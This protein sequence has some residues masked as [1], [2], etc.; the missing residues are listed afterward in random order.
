MSAEIVEDKSAQETPAPNKKKKLII[1]GAATVAALTLGGGGAAFF[2]GGKSATKTEAHGEET[3]AADEGHGE[4]DAKE[5]EGGHG[6]GEGK[7]KFVDVPT[8]SVNLRSPDGAPRFLKLH[9]MLVPGPKTTDAALKDKLPVVLDAYQPFLRE[10][11]PEDL[12]GSAAVYRLKEEL[13]VRATRVLGPGMVKE[14]LIQDL[15]QQ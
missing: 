10:L 2:M 1:I 9:L 8:V 5:G 7:G 3:A 13:M 4:G 15:I 14:V 6:E 12:G 11:R